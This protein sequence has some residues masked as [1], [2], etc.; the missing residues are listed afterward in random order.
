MAVLLLLAATILLAAC[1]GGDDDADPTA[2]AE[3]TVTEA[4]EGTTATS[5][6]EAEETE[7]ASPTETEAEATA[8][9]TESEATATETKTE[10][11]EASPTIPEGVDPQAAEELLAALPTEEAVPAG[12]TLTE[13][14]VAGYDDVTADADDPEARRAELEEWGF[15]GAARRTFESGQSM[16]TAA[17]T[18]DQTLL[19][20]TLGMRLGTPEFADAQL[21]K[22]RD[23]YLNDPE[24][25]LEEVSIDAI[26][27]NS[28]AA[29]GES[30][31]QGTPVQIGAVWVRQGT[32]VF[33]FGGIAGTNV[34]IISQLTELA[35][36]SLGTGGSEQT[37]IGEPPALGGVIYSTNFE[38][39]QQDTFDAGSLTHN[40]DVYRLT[41]NPPPGTYVS[42]FT[43]GSE[44][45]G[46]LSATVEMRQTSGP[47]QSEGCVMLRVDPEAQ[48]YDYAFCVSSTGYTNAV[49]E[50]FDD[51]GGYEFETI[52]E[53]NVAESVSLSEWTTLQMI[54]Q[55]NKFWFLVNGELVGTAQH[56]GPT[57]GEVGIVVN[58]FAEAPVEFEYRNL[59]VHALQ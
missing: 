37:D 53:G 21:A 49:Y 26:G 19:I 47:E 48:N 56:D 8:T 25:T 13:E 50:T 33:R 39:W 1:G 18:A 11:A 14:V 3:P 38:D 22:D 51:A 54:A 59:E 30:D 45:F 55:G 9:E 42:A 28:A 10:D 58:N 41:V 27:D 15:A 4:A 20:S 7:A 32:D 6:E 52:F 35:K 36:T 43:T 29:L 2:T 23:D 40:G 44:Q 57:T 31:A 5:T 17:T 12:L 16:A 46:D 24:L 34:D